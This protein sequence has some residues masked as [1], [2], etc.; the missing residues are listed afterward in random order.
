MMAISKKWKT[1]PKKE[2]FRKEQFDILYHYYEDSE[3][4]DPIEDD[5]LI[6]LN[7]LQVYNQYRAKHTI[8]FPAEI[9]EIRETYN[10]S[11]AKMSEIL[12]FGINQYRNYEKGEIPS[13][14]NGRLIQMIKNPKEFKRILS[15]SDFDNDSKLIEKVDGLIQ[16]EEEKWWK[17]LDITTYIV[18]SDR[19][20]GK[21]GFMKPSLDKICN[22]TLFFAKETKKPFKTKMNKLL[23][24]ADFFHYKRSCFS[25]S[26]T[27]YRA[28]QFG[29]VPQNFE[30]LYEFAARLEFININYIETSIGNVIEQHLPSASKS[31]D[32]SLFSDIELETLEIVAKKFKETSTQDIVE[33]SH[34]EDAWKE[35]EEAHS[36]ID[37]QRAFTLKY[38]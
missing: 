3:T 29:P 12:G 33:M 38:L 35:N 2:I 30:S 13:I 14:S 21:T 16:E 34:E 4:G 23:F 11:A 19:P 22:M 1:V 32:T 18:G 8:P 17:N 28:I 6:Q 15:L 24:Y 20:N 9:K 31:F 36:I 37:Y 26:G 25:I 10:L 27:Q 7:H 5:E